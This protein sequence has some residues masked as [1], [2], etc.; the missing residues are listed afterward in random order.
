MALAA[1]FALVVVGAV[2]SLQLVEG[3][4]ASSWRAAALEPRAL[5]ALTRALRWE[6]GARSGSL[7]GAG[8]AAG[9]TWRVSW[10]PAPAVA[11]MPWPCVR[12][13]VSTSA[14]AARHQDL[15]TVALRAEPWAMGVTCSGDLDAATSLSV[16]GSGVYVGGCLRG[17][18]NLAFPAAA[19]S[20]AAAGEPAD[21]V[22]GDVFATAAAHGGVGIWALGEEIHAAGVAV[23]YPAD[24]D[25]H[26]G[27]AVPGE[28][29][30]GPGAEFL[31]AAAESA[32]SPGAAFS[33]GTLRLG[34]VRPAG[35]G[36]LLNGRCLLLPPGDEVTIEG[37]ASPDAG[38]LLVVV[39]GDAVLGQPGAP[40]EL[41]GALVVLG[42]LVV[43][44]GLLLRGSLHAENLVI[45]AESSIA[46][47]PGW[48]ER[49]LSGA[50]AP[51]IVESGA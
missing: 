5:A 7:E 19:G 2:H 17:R 38:R 44:G 36:E 15:L 3:S 10:E 20:V 49:P 30:E 22:R 50:T 8:P 45:E 37:S 43:R 46:V 34:A 1:T 9:E 40:V 23:P 32:E 25:R 31:C 33:E 13:S 41:D 47:D 27:L 26:E 21:L 29:L 14:G 12:A 11:G 35:A 24:S 42:R 28:W 51:V 18:E 39:Q 6:P 16:I 48:R 4:D